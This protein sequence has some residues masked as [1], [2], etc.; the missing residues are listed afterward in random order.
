MPPVIRWRGRLAAGFI[1]AWVGSAS[2]APESAPPPP[3]IEFEA[4][5]FDAGPVRQG[6]AIRHRFAFRNTGGRPLRLLDLR[7][8][9]DS[10]V[11]QQAPDVV[12]AGGSGS[13]EVEIDTTNLA[14]PVRRTLTLFANDP[15]AP[16]TRLAIEAVVEPLVVV[17]PRELYV[18][19][20]A[21]GKRAEADVRLRFAG[22]D[23]DLL[24]IE[25]TSA[26]IVPHGFGA[27]SRGEH[28]IR[29]A[30]APDAPPGTFVETLLVRTNHPER[31]EIRIPVAGHILNDDAAVR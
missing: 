19:R 13:L 21:P 2:C 22:D 5:T 8:S 28:R 18:G 23:I 24:S 25:A 26:V 15:A 20:L 11:T 3:R 30:I 7:A 6:A 17:E 9:C 16:L 12:A 27:D 31:R 10:T 1:A 4:I 14:G 29:V